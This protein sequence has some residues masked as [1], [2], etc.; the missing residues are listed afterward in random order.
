[1]H[2][3]G[4]MAGLDAAGRGDCRRRERPQGGRD[5]G[6]AGRPQP[7]VGR[8]FRPPFRGCRGRLAGRGCRARM[9]RLGR[10]R[11]I[12]TLWTSSCK[13]SRSRP[14]GRRLSAGR[15]RRPARAGPDDGARDVVQGVGFRPFV[16]RLARALGIGGWVANTS[17]GVTIEAEG[18]PE[19]LAGF[20][21]AIRQDR[22]PPA[23]RRRGRGRCRWH[24]SGE[25]GFAIGPSAEAGARS[26]IVLPDLATCADCLARDLRPAQPPLPLSLHQL[27]P[28]RPA[29]QHH[30]RSALRPRP[31]VD[32][33][34]PDVL[35]LPGRVRGSGGPAFPRRAECLPRLRAELDAV[36]RGGAASLPIA[37]RH[38]WRPPPRSAMAPSLR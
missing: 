35:G 23:A 8:P 4:L 17:A 10:H 14:D 19:A 22:P 36:G 34:L 32:A 6:L 30:R 27:H 20:V 16:Y 28:L 24:R 33:P 12:R 9:H 21:R 1:M 18:T 25:A 3:H 29:L 26:A 11:T 37:K 31:H 7:H 38:C 5:L 2:E 13:A 15:A